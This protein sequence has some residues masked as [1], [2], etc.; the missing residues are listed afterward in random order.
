M[1]APWFIHIVVPIASAGI[2]LPLS[3]MWLVDAGGD[4][5]RLA[6]ALAPSLFCGATGYLLFL[7]IRWLCPSGEEEQNAK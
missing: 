2:G 1:D 7:V 6:I 4:L 5:E 3:I